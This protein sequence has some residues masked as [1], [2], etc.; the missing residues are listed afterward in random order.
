[1]L[2]VVRGCRGKE[3]REGGDA[4]KERRVGLI[5]AEERGAWDPARSDGGSEPAGSF[6][7]MDGRTDAGVG[8]REQWEKAKPERSGCKPV[9]EWTFGVDAE[10][11]WLATQT[12]RTQVTAGRRPQRERAR[13]RG[14]GMGRARSSAHELVT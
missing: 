1:M 12:Q 11:D 14:E 3:G 6:L 4:G 8:E 7:L 5:P 10:I 9:G 2:R 13:A